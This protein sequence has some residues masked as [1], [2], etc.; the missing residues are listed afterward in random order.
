[1]TGVRQPELLLDVR[2]LPTTFIMPWFLLQSTLRLSDFDL[3]LANGESGPGLNS[4][5]D[6]ILL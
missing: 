3:G 5:E 6:E 4:L 1:M 2:L